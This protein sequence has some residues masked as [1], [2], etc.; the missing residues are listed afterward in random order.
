MGG[1]KISIATVLLFGI[2]Q[3]D[4]DSLG[5]VI[6]GRDE[7]RRAIADLLSDARA[8]RS[9]V[10]VLRGEAG[11]GKSTMLRAAVEAAHGMDVLSCSG[12]ESEIRL[13]FSGLHQ[14][15]G[16]VLDRLDELPDVQA[17]ALRGALGL[18]E[19]RA[20]ELLVAAGVLTLLATVAEQRPLLI[21]VDDAQWLDQSSAAALL[22]TF[23]R[24]LAEPIAALVA[25]RD[26]EPTLL[27][28]ADLPELRLDGL[29]PA[30]AAALLDQLGWHGAP[31][32]RDTLVELTA[33]NPLALS[34][35]V[36]G[37]HADEIVEQMTL[38]GTVPLSARLHAAFIHGVDQL[39]AEARSLLLVA[40]TEE[41]GRR[42]TVLGAA[43][44]L[45]VPADALDAV[46]R[47]ELVES[48]GRQV[49]FRHPL[50]R[51]A[52]YQSVSSV[53]RATV[54]RALGDQLRAAGQLDR[55][56]WHHA[57]AATGPDEELAEALERSAEANER[58]GGSAASAA[59]LQLAARL[60]TTARGRIRRLVTAA[61][62]SWDAGQIGQ[63]ETLVRQVLAEGP[64]Q[65]TSARLAHL[66][67]L[68]EIAT[69][70]PMI[71]YDQLSYAGEMFGAD[72]PAEAASIL[73]I[74]ADAAYHAN[75]MADAVAAAQRIATLDGDNY[76]RLGTWLA[77]ATEGSLPETGTEP[78]QI[79]EALDGIVG[80]HH[81]LREIWPL[82]L[83]WLGP[84][85]RQAR[86][87]GVQ[88]ARRLRSA[89]MPAALATL[90]SWLVDLDYQLGHWPA[91]LA[92]AEEGLGFARE[93]RQWTR[94][95][96]LLAL[97]ARL[98]A[99]QGQ[100]AACQ[101]DAEQ[102]LEV[103]LR[104]HNRAAAA[105]ATWALGQ[106]ALTTGD[107]EAGYDRLVELDTPNGPTAHQQI[108]R[109][110]MPDLVE[111]AVRT[112]HHEV[113]TTTLAAF[114]SWAQ[115]STLPWA[116]AHLH[117]CKALL[118]DNDTA[119]EH[120]RL[121]LS[122]P[123]IQDRPFDHARTALL[124]GEWLRRNR[125]QVAARPQL[126]LAAQ[127]LDALGAIALADRARS[128]LRAAGGSADHAVTRLNI[129]ELTPQE[130]Q[131]AR[132]AATGLSNKEIGGQ[133]FLS[134]R[135]VAYHLHKLFPKLGITTRAQLRDLDLGE[136]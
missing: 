9:G 92:H 134:P 50:I 84:H 10:L 37:G 66:R 6:V 29:R 90:M 51:S 5:G 25:I 104:Q 44:R 125:E 39:P 15:L 101:R 79:A 18:S 97:R 65:A 24:L 89:G 12:V 129:R 77:A 87:F 42:D 76:H 19:D 31:A 49:R 60:S 45:G 130:L 120:F 103:A 122:T 1:E 41:T 64:D 16:G 117:R 106:L 93:T 69:G 112:E 68:M 56:T 70:D 115:R 73:F 98:T 127:L 126:R 46:E 123:G 107:A 32:M 11:V 131:V 52:V 22:F 96:A 75:H 118:A 72:S 57:L 43:A 99:G 26:P 91:G 27:G 55:A 105:N 2:R 133:L 4:W 34:E 13:A 81:P 111:A 128:E 17:T 8:D 36:K 28:T 95:A 78:V 113:A 35:L 110:A 3:H 74:A 109:A 83:G 114:S 80:P 53:A 108:L 7:E 71:A 67:G 119:D 21:V 100:R 124:Y 38:A 40:A 88:A 82:V 85:H 59:G 48:D 136:I 132:L 47:A 58:R 102:A 14:L 121:A 61:F 33:G 30:P 135:T 116:H 63:A 86:A 20:A 54:H 94:I 62:A 23:R